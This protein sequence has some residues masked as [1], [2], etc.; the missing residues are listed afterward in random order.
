MVYI[1]FCLDQLVLFFMFPLLLTLTCFYSAD[2]IPC[3]CNNFNIEVVF[4]LQC[5]I[6]L[7]QTKL[8]KK[9]VIFCKSM[10]KKLLR[11]VHDEFVALIFFSSDMKLNF[12]PI[13]TKQVSGQNRVIFIFSS[14]KFL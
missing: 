7:G 5:D 11:S 2:S 6:S 8:M 13:S 14:L 3:L 1:F 10:V 4:L 12:E 9:L